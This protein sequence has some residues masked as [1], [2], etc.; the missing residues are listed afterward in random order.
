[1]S[2]SSLEMEKEFLIEAL[3]LIK[4]DILFKNVTEGVQKAQGVAIVF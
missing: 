4:Y 3:H 1:M 2:L